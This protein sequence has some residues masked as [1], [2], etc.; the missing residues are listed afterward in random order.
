MKRYKIIIL[1]MLIAAII[2]CGGHRIKIDANNI[3]MDGVEIWDIDYRIVTLNSTL[4]IN[5]ADEMIEGKWVGLHS[6]RI[7]S[8][9]IFLYINHN[10]IV[11]YIC[12][13]VHI[14]QYY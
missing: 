4:E 9:K 7:G 2:S 11:I 1:I 10:T 12:N 5:V 6:A 8:D 3:D 13:T 14:L